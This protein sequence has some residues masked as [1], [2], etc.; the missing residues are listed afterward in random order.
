MTAYTAPQIEA[1]GGRPWNKQDGTRRIYLNPKIWAPWIGLDVAYYKTGNVSSA[2]LNG[3]AI[4]NAEARRILNAKVYWE[5]GQVVCDY[6]PLRTQILKAVAA[7][8]R[9]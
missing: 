6:P 2:A 5:N 3:E 9:A 4:S 8:V 7:Q 1:I